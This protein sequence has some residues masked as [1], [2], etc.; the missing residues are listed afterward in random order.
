MYIS[1][2]KKSL[3]LI[4]LFPLLCVSC[5]HTQ[6]ASVL[7]KGGS[8]YSIVAQAPDEQSAFNKAES[9]ARYTCKQ[10]QKQLIVIEDESLYQGPDKEDRDNVDG[11]NVALAMF[12]GRSG[13]ERGA[14]DYKV[15]LLIACK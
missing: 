12:T 2:F 1:T 13:K 11:G 5:G 15:T 6:E 14:E 10:E 4:P 3:T 7:P 9:E 8:E